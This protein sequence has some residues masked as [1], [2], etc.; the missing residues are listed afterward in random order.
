L[1]T[2]L[3]FGLT[4]VFWRRTMCVDFCF[5]SPCVLHALL[6]PNNLPQQ[7]VLDTPQ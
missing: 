7:F 1:S 6:D 3:R 4:S 2:H 5:A